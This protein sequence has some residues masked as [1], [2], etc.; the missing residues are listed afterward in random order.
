MRNFRLLKYFNILY[1]NEG[2]TLIQV[3][4]WCVVSLAVTSAV[5]SMRHQP[6]DHV[7]MPSISQVPPKRG[8]CWMREGVWPK[9][10]IKYKTTIIQKNGKTLCLQF[11]K[12]NQRSHMP[13]WRWRRSWKQEQGAGNW[14]WSCEESASLG[15]C[16]LHCRCAVVLRQINLFGG[17]TWRW[18][19][20]KQPQNIS[21]D[22]FNFAAKEKWKQPATKETL[23]IIV[24]VNFGSSQELGVR[25]RGSGKGIII[26]SGSLGNPK[27]N[28]THH[29]RQQRLFFCCLSVWK[30]TFLCFRQDV[31]DTP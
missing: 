27:P 8:S 25:S 23:H 4:L 20:Q 19:Q 6:L 5:S 9:N 22:I 16:R 10:Q 12:G 26:I 1:Y 30:L 28:E 31:A 29:L 7:A 18:L 11:G 3:Q 13:G 2:N 17:A 24:I 14:S 21:R 15:E